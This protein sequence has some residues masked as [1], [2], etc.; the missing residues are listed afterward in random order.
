M[1]FNGSRS[2]VFFPRFFFLV[3]NVNSDKEDKLVHL[4]LKLQL[5]AQYISE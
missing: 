5:S 4:A 2:Y 1:L 3:V